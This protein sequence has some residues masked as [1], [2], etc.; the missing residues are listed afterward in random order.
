MDWLGLCMA[1]YAFW[2]LPGVLIELYNECNGNWEH[3][4]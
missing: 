3:T 2:W 4:K 1:V